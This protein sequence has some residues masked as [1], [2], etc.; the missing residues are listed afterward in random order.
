MGHA[1]LLERGGDSPNLAFRAGD[2]GGDF[3]QNLQ[4]RC[5]DAIVIGDQ[6]AHHQPFA[7]WLI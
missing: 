2:F 1:R 5:V 4:P 7:A 3:G 6:N